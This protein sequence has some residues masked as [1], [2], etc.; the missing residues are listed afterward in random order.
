M[1]LWTP[2]NKGILR[3]Q[4]NTGDVGTTNPGTLVTTGA[5][6]SV[7]G[8][9]A[10]LI[11]STSFDAYKIVIMASH[12]G[13]S[14]IGSAGCLDILIGA[15]TEEVLIS[16]LLMG[17]SGAYAVAGRGPKIWEFPLYI[18][19][20][21]RIAAQAAGERLSTGMRVQVYLYGGKGTPSNPIGG[22][23]TTYGMATIP[24][25]TTVVAGANGAEGAWTQI[26]ASTIQSHFAFVPSF[27]VSPADTSINARSLQLDLGIGAATEK[28]IGAPFW[29]A[30]DTSET[31]SGP[32]PQTPTFHDVPAGTRLVMRA[33]C[34]G[35]VDGYQGAIHAIS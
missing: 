25:G 15:S 2:P 24:N 31:M 17:Y 8:T 35:S 18:P 23:V 34:S 3:V 9:P 20:G 1:I 29:F 6:S 12:Y 27:Q 13:V 28:A 7:K 30:T 14:A 16:N 21:S 22:K 10:E 32:Y 5:S 11:S 4:H 19:A 26:T 33:S